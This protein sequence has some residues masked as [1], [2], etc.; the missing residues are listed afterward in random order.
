MIFAQHMD[1]PVCLGLEGVPRCDTWSVETGTV[2]GKPG[3]IGH[4]SQGEQI[5]KRDR[6]PFQ[7]GNSEMFAL[8]AKI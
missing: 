1:L 6:D 3:H 2:L 5:S 4:S 7:L 8:E